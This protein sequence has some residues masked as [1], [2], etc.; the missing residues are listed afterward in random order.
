MKRLDGKAKHDM[1]GSCVTGP[2]HVIGDS[3]GGDGLERMRP[4]A[5]LN[6]SLWYHL[7]TRSYVC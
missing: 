6:I 5:R 1:S 3:L 7:K 2:K 4:M